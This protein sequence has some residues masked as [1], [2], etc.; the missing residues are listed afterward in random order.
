M[1]LELH[2]LVEVRPGVDPMTLFDREARAI[3]MIA[4]PAQVFVYA[5]RIGTVDMDALRSRFATSGASTTSRGTR[6]R[7]R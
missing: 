5:A 1:Y 6:T 2:A 3:M 4:S 7:A